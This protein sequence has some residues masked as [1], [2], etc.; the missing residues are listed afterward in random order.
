M[1][2]SFRTSSFSHF[3]TPQW[4]WDPTLNSD[5]SSTALGV[6]AIIL[7][8]TT[9]AF[10]RSLTEAVGP[11]TSAALIYLM[12]GVAGCG[13]LAA[14]GRFRLGLRSGSPRYWIGCGGLFLFYMV[15]LYLALGL[16]ADRIQV[17]EVGLVNYLWPMLTLLLSVPILRMKARAWLIPGALTATL[18]IFLATAQNRPLSLQ[19]SLWNLTHNPV[20]Y[21]LALLA[22]V[23]WA[24]YSVLSRRWGG[25]GNNQAVPVFMLVT[26]IVLAVATRFTAEQPQWST[27]SVLELVYAA[28]G[29]NLA[30]VFWE[31]AMQR[32]DVVLV[33]SCSYLTPLLS[34]V[35]TSIYLGIAPGA[36][37]WAGCV[38]IILGAVVCKLS[39]AETRR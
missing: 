21:L 20:P 31:R 33:A 13:Y 2:S 16:A 4:D 10:V 9:V 15:C 6:A 12:G 5:A 11:I 35:I 24:F 29:P 23:S 8:S 22:A 36:K 25:D 27:R 34:T 18:G 30:Y 7:W 39:V 19:A 3:R 38:M 32:G 1:G 26:G 14:K 28:T 37:L 17:L